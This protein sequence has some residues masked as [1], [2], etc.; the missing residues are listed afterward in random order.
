MLLA[1]FWFRG[2]APIARSHDQLLREREIALVQHRMPADDRLVAL[3]AAPGT[4]A[5]DL[6]PGSS[7]AT[8]YATLYVQ[9]GDPWVALLVRDLPP[10]PAGTTY[11]LWVANDNSLVPLGVFAARG[12]GATEL[13]ALAPAQ[14]ETYTDFMVTVEPHGGAATPS[15]A[16]VWQ[17]KL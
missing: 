2:T 16:I 5:Y 17:V 12:D 1:L 8:A 4:V 13:V 7:T 11:Q 14:I 3:L 9:R 6:I 10:A 15:S